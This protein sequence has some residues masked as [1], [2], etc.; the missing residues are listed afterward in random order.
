MIKLNNIYKEIIYE[1]LKPSEFKRLYSIARD[2]AN[3]R[4]DSVWSNLK[5]QSFSQNRNG[6]RLYF[7]VEEDQDNDALEYEISDYL[8]SKGFEIV[9]FKTNQAKKQGDKNITKIGKI[10]TM[11]GKSDPQA[12]KFLNKFNTTS[13]RGGSKISPLIVISRSAYDIGGASTDRGWSSCMNLRGGTNR[14]YIDFDISQGSMV[15]Y[16]IRPDDLNIRN[17]MA[18]V[19]IKPYI[20]Y[21][22]EDVL[23]GIEGTE[24]G[25]APASFRKTIIKM[26]DIAQQEKVGVFEIDE[27]LYRDSIKPNI[28]KMDPKKI[29]TVKFKLEGKVKELKDGLTYEMILTD[30]SWLLEAD[31]SDAV[32]GVYDKGLIWYDGVWRN[33]TWRNGTWE[34]G[35]WENGVWDGGVWKHGTWKRGEW[36]WG[37][38]KN[39]RWKLGTW[40]NGSWLNGIWENGAWEGGVWFDGEWK[41]GVWEDGNWVGG[42]WVNGT[43][44][45]GAW[46]Y[47]SWR[48]GTWRKGEWGDGTWYDGV[49]KNG[50]WVSGTW[51]WGTWEGGYWQTGYWYG[52][53]WKDGTWINGAWNEGKWKDGTWQNG[54]WYNGTWEG[55]DW[56]YGIWRNGIWKGGKWKDGHW[57]GGTWKSSE[58]HPNER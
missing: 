29:E 7:N 48:N 27:N 33:G 26:L 44:N 3:K 46:T 30:Y 58:P 47:G 42:I 4:I 40:R 11:L 36:K 22:G 8:D 19:F 56:E 24:Y 43:W 13:A 31:F 14:Y 16:Y 35:T 9:D 45:D 57:L 21:S 12:I 54:Y 52:G 6:E 32:L 28:V 10:L 49:W 23:Y 37:T 51:E 1:A 55:G 38:W 17:P 2:V 41:K 15:A 18:R 39:G 34:N 53:V 50:T 20:S 25:T 5:S